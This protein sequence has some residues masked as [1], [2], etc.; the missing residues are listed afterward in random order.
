MI[1]HNSPEQFTLFPTDPEPQPP[2]DN[3]TSGEIELVSFREL[4]PEINDTGYLTHAIFAYPAKFIPQV[5]RYAINT[6][7]KQGD[8]IVGSVRGLWD[9]GG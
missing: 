1:N 6:Y 5:V 2:A 3:A 9:G 8:W 7:T 4:V